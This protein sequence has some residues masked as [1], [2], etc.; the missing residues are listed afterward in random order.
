LLAAVKG[1]EVDV[2]VVW[3]TDRLYR[4]MQDL[5]EYISVCQPRNVPTMAV[6]TSLLDLTTPSGRMVARTLGSVAQYESEQKAERQKRANLQRALQ[7]RHFSTQRVFGYQP[8]GLALREDEAAA[9][10]QAYQAV[11]D[12]SSL[13]AIC[14][15]LNNAGFRTAKKGNLWDSTVLSQM[16]KSPRFAGF[17]VYHREILTGPDGKPVKGEWP[18]V[19]D[20]ETWYATHTILTDPSRRWEHPPDQLLSGVARCATCDAVMHS[21]GQRNGRRRYRCSLMAGHACRESA[22]IDDFVTNV[23][24]ALLS[25]PNVLAEIAPPQDAGRSREIR[26]ELASLQQRSDGLVAA[27]TDGTI[28][29]QQLQTGQA[30]LARRREELEGLL[31]VPTGSVLRRLTGTPEPAQLWAALD[32]DERRQ[33]IDDLLIIKV[34]AART[35]EATY[36]DWRKRI[37]NPS[38]LQLTWKHDIAQASRDEAL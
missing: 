1:G 34:V 35:K 32:I 24:L 17:R 3:H 2:V 38:S 30:R 36:L 25:T 31:P 16:L 26:H 27:F 14:R 19:V 37:L 9:V 28:T 4:R 7:G 6:Q 15:R 11:L 13:A 12:G 8:D 33:V 20:E 5:E 21:G 22:P 10:R 29:L 23:V 18:A